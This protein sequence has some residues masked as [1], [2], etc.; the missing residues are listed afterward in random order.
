MAGK[1]KQPV[2]ASPTAMFALSEA[3]ALGPR[4]RAVKLDVFGTCGARGVVSVPSCLPVVDAVAV[5]A[6]H[7]ISSVPVVSPTAA[8]DATW[9]E[10]YEVA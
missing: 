8:P 9:R 10:K 5:M 4:L 6:Q 1:H 2:A 7:G 3:A